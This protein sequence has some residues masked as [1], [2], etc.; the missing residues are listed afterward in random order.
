MKIAL[1]CAILRLPGACLGE[2]KQ[3]WALAMAAELETAIEEGAPLQFALGCLIAA[4]RGLVTA[5]EG[6]FILTSYAVALGILLPMAALQIGCALFGLPYLY[7]GQHGLVGAMLDGGLQE[8]LLRG[9][10]QSAIPT[11]ALLQVLIG[12]GHLRIAWVLLERDW[13]AALRWGSASLSASATLVTFMGVLFVDGR[14]ALLQGVVLAIE[15]AMIAV[16]A[17]WHGNFAPSPKCRAAR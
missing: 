17:R 14:Q 11:L 7:P 6:R 16:V 3:D 10:Y 13:A 5:D 4:G 1:A 8:S 15:L 9:V 2:R 12:L